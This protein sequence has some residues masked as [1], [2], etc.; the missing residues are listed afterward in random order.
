M[1]NRNVHSVLKCHISEAH[2]FVKI[3]SFTA[4]HAPEAARAI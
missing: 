1:G 2:D 4:G 3:S